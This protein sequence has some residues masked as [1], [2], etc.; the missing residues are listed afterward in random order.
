MREL[1]AR[2]GLRVRGRFCDS[3]QAFCLFLIA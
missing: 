1:L 2:Q 3:E